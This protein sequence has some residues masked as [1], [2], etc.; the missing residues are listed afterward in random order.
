MIEKINRR[1]AQSLEVGQEGTLLW[2]E[3][4]NMDGTFSFVLNFEEEDDLFGILYLRKEQR[5]LDANPELKQ[6]GNN[7]NS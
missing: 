7:E 3:V 6:K 5:V 2:I 1:L 4:N